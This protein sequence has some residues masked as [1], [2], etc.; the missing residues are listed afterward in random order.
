MSVDDEEE[1]EDNGFLDTLS[2]FSDTDWKDW[3]GNEQEDEETDI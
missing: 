2:G 1:V 3:E